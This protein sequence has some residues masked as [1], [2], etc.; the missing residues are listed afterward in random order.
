MDTRGKFRRVEGIEAWVVSLL[1]E[2][3]LSRSLMVLT[4]HDV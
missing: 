3:K 2:L 4:R 1:V